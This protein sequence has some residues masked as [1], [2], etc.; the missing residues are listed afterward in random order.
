LITAGS[1]PLIYAVFKTIVDEGDKVIYPIPS[2]NN[3]HYAYLTTANAVE[4]QTQESNNFLPTADD[5]VHMLMALFCSV[6][7]LH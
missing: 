3:N 6:F 5:F 2:W 1:R 4:V 7:V